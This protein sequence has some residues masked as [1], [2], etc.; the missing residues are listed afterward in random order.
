MLAGEV[1]HR[2]AQSRQRKGAGCCHR[3]YVHPSLPSH[4]VAGKDKEPV[5][6]YDL[7]LQGTAGTEAATVSACSSKGPAGHL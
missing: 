1:L 5:N 6:I 4:P 3:C 2:A 7:L